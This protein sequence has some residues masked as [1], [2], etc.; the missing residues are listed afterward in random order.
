[1]Q[2]A[3]TREDSRT[4]D[5]FTIHSIGIPGMVLMENAGRGITQAI[6]EILQ[7][8][9]G[10]AVY[11]L[12]GK[13]NNGGDGFVVA[14]YLL[15]ANLDVRVFHIA[16]EDEYSGDAERNFQ[17]LKQLTDQ[18]YHVPDVQT[19]NEL[20]A[21]MFAADVLLDALLGTGIKGAPRAPYDEFIE[22]I[23]SYNAPTV[24]VD[25]PTG[26]DANSGQIPGNAVQAEETVTMGFTKTGLLFSPGREFSGQVSVVDIGIPDQ[27]LNQADHIY[28]I[29][30]DDDIFYR[31]PIRESDIYKH[32][33]G[34]VFTLCGARGFTGAAT[35]VSEASLVTGA[36]LILAGVPESLNP[37]VES[38]MTEVISVPLPETS[39]GTYSEAAFEPLQEHFE[40]SHVLA[41]GSGMT[42]NQETQNLIDKILRT[43]EKTVVVDAD[44]C[45]HY[46]PET[47]KELKSCPGEI[48]LTP[49][50]GEFG[51]MTGST[52]HELAENRLE[53]ARDFATEYNVTLV[54]KGAPTIIADASG[55]VFINPNG[56]PGMASAGTGDVL[57]GI[58]AGLA[59]QG[60]PPMDAAVV[61]CYLHGLAGDLAAEELTQLSVTAGSLIAYLPEAIGFIQS[62]YEHV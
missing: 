43:Y 50:W 41:L 14:R 26:V 8:R 34:K 11:V 46:N 5:N 51:K 3:L 56:N 28:H 38:K 42:Q 24:A 31:L 36:G 40:W 48:I 20:T 23:N 62:Y 47:M 39:E 33:A 9:G 53:I 7:E 18:I 52:K 15:N 32:K 61:A 58:I 45:T 30:E 57:A 59:G 55:H 12:A 49:H 35:M 44:A 37:I 29:P 60:L 25:I 2:Y 13:G 4:L 54:L 22:W 21:D 6:L 27:A 17:I 1:M 16:K 10:L 19:L